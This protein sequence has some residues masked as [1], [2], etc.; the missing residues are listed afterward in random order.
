[1]VETGRQKAG[2]HSFVKV[3]LIANYERDDKLQKNLELQK[4]PSKLKFENNSHFVDK[5]TQR[6]RSI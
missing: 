6:F 3:I 2:K 5:I 1:M 4:M